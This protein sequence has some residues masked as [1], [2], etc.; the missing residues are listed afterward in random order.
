[1]HALAMKTRLSQVLPNSETK[2]KCRCNGIQ[3]LNVIPLPLCDTAADC[4]RRELLTINLNVT[5]TTF[6]LCA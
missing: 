5:A 3:M 1:M 6:S 2:L 4:N